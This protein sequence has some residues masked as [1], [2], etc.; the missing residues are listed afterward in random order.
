MDYRSPVAGLQRQVD[1]L[2]EQ[3]RAQ[4]ETEASESEALT[5]LRR[6]VVR[7]EKRAN[8]HR[9]KVHARELTP[10]ERTQYARM[11]GAGVLAL[12]LGALGSVYLVVMT[13]LGAPFEDNQ[14]HVAMAA[15]LAV[16]GG[17]VFVLMARVDARR[18]RAGRVAE[19]DFSSSD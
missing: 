11:H 18:R 4:G 1:E 13:L 6:E 7:A 5:K 12:L 15:G 3:L 10:R 2:T 8:R 9:K 14:I 16:M 17:A 19:D